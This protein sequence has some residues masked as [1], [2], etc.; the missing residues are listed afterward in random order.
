MGNIARRGNGWRA[1]Y[2]DENGRQHARHFATKT[3]G[4]QWLDQVTASVVTGTYVDP[5]AGKRTVRE[6]AEDWQAAQ[7]GADNT[8]AITDN[9]IRLHIIPALGSRPIGSVRKMEIQSLVKEWSEQYKPGTVRNYYDVLARIFA[10]AVEDKVRTDSPCKR[11]TLPAMPEHEVVPPTIGEV[12]RLAD[13]MPDRYR[14][15][16]I[17]L[18][19]SGIRI[20]ELLALKTHDVLIPFQ[21]IRVERQRLQ[22]G[23]VSPPKSKRPR[24]VP[25]GQVVLAALQDHL[26]DY[27]SDEWLF[28]DSSGGPL[29]YQTWQRAW[30]PGRKMAGCPE[31]LTHDLR[32]FFAS[33][34]IAGG[35]S[36]KMVQLALGHSSPMIT[37]RVY[38]H[39]FEGDEDRTRSVMDAALKIL[40][41]RGGL[42]EAQN[43]PA[44]GQT[45]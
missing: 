30:R 15:A 5:K 6:F 23:V 11:V 19:G 12:Q 44:A 37:L 24:N 26:R 3:K 27:P 32:H 43:I 7:I 29:S 45:G 36:V 22:S 33:A 25:V 9:A 31:M 1:R 18:A 8:L 20:G 14:A 41:T 17:L 10:A 4:Q 2:R 39:L 38:A 21:T 28:T 34:L 16:V 40:G 35:A 42:D 13:A